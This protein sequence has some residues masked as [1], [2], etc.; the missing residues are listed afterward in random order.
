MDT[1]FRLDDTVE[2]SLQ[3]LQT[4]TS[5]GQS[6]A[7]VIAGVKTYA[8]TNHV[9]HRGRLF[10]V[11]P[12]QNEFWHEPVVYCYSWSIRSRTTKGW[13][14]HLKKDDRYTLIHGEA[15]SV[16]YDAR[17]DWPGT[18]GASVRP[19]HETA[20]NSQGRLAHHTQSD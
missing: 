2:A 6:V 13:G 18:G 14:L 8:P 1:P 7:P 5:S 17:L 12:G 10:E 11:Y 19:W 9:D 20:L 3:D 15:L 16:L 4:V